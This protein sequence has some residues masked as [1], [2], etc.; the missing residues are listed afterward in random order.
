ME[1]SYPR[2]QAAVVQTAPIL[3]D[4]EASVEKACRLICEAAAE[5]AQL[6]LFPEAF[7]SEVTRARFDFDVVGHYARPDVFRQG[8][9]HDVGQ[10]PGRQ[11][12]RRPRPRPFRAL[13]P[14]P[15]HGLG[16]SARPSGMRHAT[17]MWQMPS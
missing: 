12:A 11:G 4:R 16:T 8:P 7:I 17:G 3:F 14:V 9:A 15:V 6:I 10:Q 5:G 1:E 13:P 2:A